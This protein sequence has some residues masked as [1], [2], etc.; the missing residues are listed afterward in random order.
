MT[1]DKF[2]IKQKVELVEEKIRRNF[3]YWLDIC[4]QKM[5]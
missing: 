3:S 2:N 5:E 4:N 1:Q